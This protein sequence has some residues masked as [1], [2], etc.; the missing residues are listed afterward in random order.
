MR[1]APFLPPGPSPKPR[2]RPPRERERDRPAPPPPDETPPPVP[3]GT[4]PRDAT[5]RPSSSN[6][7]G[8]G[9]GGG[10]G[11]IVVDDDGSVAVPDYIRLAAPDLL[12]TA[13]DVIRA[14]NDW[15]ARRLYLADDQA[16]NRDERIISDTNAEVK[17]REKRLV[18]KT[19]G[20]LMLLL[21]DKL[22]PMVAEMIAASMPARATTSDKAPEPVSV[23][24]AGPAPAAEESD[25]APSSADER[26]ARATAARNRFAAIE[27]ELAQ[28]RDMIVPG[29]EDRVVT[30]EN[31]LDARRAENEAF[32][33]DLIMLRQEFEESTR[34]RA[35]EKQ[36]LVEK[37]DSHTNEPKQDPAAMETLQGTVADLVRTVESLKEDHKATTKA[38]D[39]RIESLVAEKNALQE[40]V[41]VLQG[42]SDQNRAEH[43]TYAAN[44][45]NFATSLTQV[46]EANRHNATTCTNRD[47]DIR[48]QI[49]R[50]QQQYNTGASQTTAQI[51]N[52]N[53]ALSQQLQGISVRVIRLERKDA[54]KEQDEMSQNR[55]VNDLAS[56]QDAVE[57]KVGDSVLDWFTKKEA[58]DARLRTQWR[59]DIEDYHRPDRQTGDSEDCAPRRPPWPGPGGPGNG[60]GGGGPSHPP[61][62]PRPPSQNGGAP[63]GGGAQRPP[64]NGLTPL[65]TTR[66]IGHIQDGSSV[67]HSP[68]DINGQRP[69][70]LSAP[71]NT[72]ALNNDATRPAVAPSASIPPSHSQM[73]PP[74]G[75][76]SSFNQI[77]ELPG[78]PLA[79]QPVI[80]FK[81]PAPGVDP[82]ARQFRSQGLYEIDFFSPIVD[83]FINSDALAQKIALGCGDYSA[84]V[85]TSQRTG[86]AWKRACERLTR[87]PSHQGWNRIQLYTTGEATTSAFTSDKDLSPEF[88]PTPAK[89]LEHIKDGKT[90][91]HA[92]VDKVRK[93]Q[94]IRRKGGVV[95]LL[96]LVGSIVAPEFKQIIDAYNDSV[97]DKSQAKIEIDSILVYETKLKDDLEATVVP[98]VNAILSRTTRSHVWFVFF[99]FQGAQ[100]IV[101]T[102]RKAGIMATATPR[103]NGI[104]IATIGDKT[105][106]Q[107]R[108]IE[109]VEV[110]TAG[111]FPTPAALY[112]A[113][114]ALS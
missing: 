8:A 58:H 3:P 19:E 112:D 40:K 78:P 11:V 35:K 95:R 1:Q 18:K 79:P 72:N 51:A 20:L 47:H 37:I 71:S 21:V 64:Q 44:L 110:D 106:S 70:A 105:A 82:Y 89:G 99:S 45:Q 102:F 50:L 92:I 113:M 55:L 88:L 39:Q 28:I 87:P 52:V 62:G 15:Q 38:Q 81:A 77:P 101:Q 111:A 98:F 46:F 14:Y 57:K 76:R 6:G 10:G 49:G 23:P 84:V 90:L 114:R 60:G 27:T 17:E 43:T 31:D 53:A 100:A 32:H 29:W 36:E 25:A 59:K 63:N 97:T 13:V 4:S 109:G 104:K 67:A 61:P 24:P 75:P 103:T 42:Q 41:A 30:L 66:H 9:G 5:L 2:E 69:P 33:D 73:P 86:T 94:I 56:R 54:A 91:A 22:R 85:A 34:A 65:L 96:R 108:V 93:N 74:A 16:L 7:G 26:K 68:A 12:K 80:F 107:L 48:T 83:E